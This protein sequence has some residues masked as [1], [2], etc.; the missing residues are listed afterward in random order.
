M[1]EIRNMTRADKEAV[2]EMMRVFYTSPAVFT[3]GSE[4]GF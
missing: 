4:A 1:V 3:N 2:I